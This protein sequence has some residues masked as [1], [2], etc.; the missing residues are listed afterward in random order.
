MAFDGPDELDAD[1]SRAATAVFRGKS[2]E[3]FKLSREQQP[4]PRRA[5][6]KY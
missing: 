1:R 3:H 2:F 5:R 6:T 4:L